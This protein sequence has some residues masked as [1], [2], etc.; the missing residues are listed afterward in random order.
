VEYSI[1]SPSAAVSL[2]VKDT[3]ALSNFLALFR[4]VPYENVD[5]LIPDLQ[6]DS[7]RLTAPS[8][9]YEVTDLSGN[10]HRITLYPMPMN[11]YS[12]TREDSTGAPLKYDLDRMLG[13]LEKDRQWVTVQHFTFD[14]LLRKYADFLSPGR[15]STGTGL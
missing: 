5:K 11:E 1:S 9:V 15:K 7:I 10:P 12:L 3:I 13:W 6:K 4:S 8:V 2:T 14:P